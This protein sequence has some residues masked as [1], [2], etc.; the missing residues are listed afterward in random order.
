M[1]DPTLCLHTASD[2]EIKCYPH[3]EE[4]YNHLHLTGQAGG[5]WILQDEGASMEDL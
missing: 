2:P 1:Q 5:D 3:K 4:I